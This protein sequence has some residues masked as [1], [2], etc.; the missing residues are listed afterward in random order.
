[1]S[2][3]VNV[4]QI[5]KTEPFFP[6]ITRDQYGSVNW[7]E[8]QIVIA[9]YFQCDPEDVGLREL[10]DGVEAI[11]VCGNIVGSF[12]YPIELKQLLAESI[13]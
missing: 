9:D 2:N 10:D 11:T 1:M 4:Y 13:I 7:W 3:F 12:T 6:L 8:K 5:G